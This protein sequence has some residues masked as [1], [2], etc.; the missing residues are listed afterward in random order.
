M[1]LNITFELFHGIVT[2]HCKLRLPTDLQARC[3]ACQQNTHFIGAM[4]N[5][6][7]RHVAEDET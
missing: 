6:L 3:L 7:R 4:K 2:L 5:N 1:L